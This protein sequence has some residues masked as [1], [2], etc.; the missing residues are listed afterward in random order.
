MRR[1]GVN[2][3][4]DRQEAHPARSGKHGQNG[5]SNDPPPIPDHPLPELGL[6][7]VHRG[8]L[9]GTIDQTRRVALSR[10]VPRR[11]FMFHSTIL[12]LQTGISRKRMHI[13][14][15]RFHFLLPLV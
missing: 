13:V 11:L 6:K 7:P 2:V 14:W 15:S 5:G 10:S 9:P 12:T 8:L 4:V 3:V 1:K